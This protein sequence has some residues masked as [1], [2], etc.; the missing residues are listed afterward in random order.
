MTCVGGPILACAPLV[1]S[2]DLV[3]YS[4]ENGVLN[5][6]IRVS[7]RSPFEDTVITSTGQDPVSIDVVA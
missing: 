3:L 6:N 5:R 4:Y 2:E 7:Q 1:R